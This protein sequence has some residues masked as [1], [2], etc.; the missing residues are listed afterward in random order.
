[1]FILQITI[2]SKYEKDTLRS[3]KVCVRVCVCFFVVFFIVVVVVCF[4]V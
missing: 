4:N 3:L 1:M 2:D